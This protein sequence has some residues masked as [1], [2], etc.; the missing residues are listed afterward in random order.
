M[1]KGR[2]RNFRYDQRTHVIRIEVPRSAHVRIEEEDGSSTVTSIDGSVVVKMDDG[3]VHA[4]DCAG[5]ITVVTDN[6]TFTQHNCTGSV[7]VQ[8]R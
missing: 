4:T 5:A 1:R 7:R 2:P 8:R 3:K 6:G